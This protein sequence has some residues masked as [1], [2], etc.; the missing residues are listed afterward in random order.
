MNFLEEEK[1]DEKDR[2][3]KFLTMHERVLPQQEWGPKKLSSY[4]E[5]CSCLRHKHN[6]E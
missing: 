1:K 4:Y 6:I 3:T 2:S 5:I